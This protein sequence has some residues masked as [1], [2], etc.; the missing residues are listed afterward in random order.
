MDDNLEDY[1]SASLTT[2]QER[3]LAFV[4]EF[5][6]R[7]AGQQH[8]LPRA[9]LKD[10]SVVAECLAIKRLIDEGFLTVPPD[11]TIRTGRDGRWR[12]SKPVASPFR[13]SAY[14][15]DLTISSADLTRHYTFTSADTRWA[16]YSGELEHEATFSNMTD[17]GSCRQKR[18]LE[19]VSSLR[20]AE[21]AGTFI[22]FIDMIHFCMVAPDIPKC[23]SLLV[24]NHAK[25]LRELLRSRQ[26]APK[27]K[28][29]IIPMLELGNAI[30][31]SMPNKTILCVKH[32]TR[33][34]RRIMRSSS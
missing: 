18:A 11:T 34:W 3:V 28:T 31:H 25:D 20:D 21:N 6:L 26:L 19:G 4:Q 12:G 14:P 33:V 24:Q 9:N 29:E 23:V 16:S 17:V 22:Q 2:S 30:S 32:W 15:C 7:R 1:A 5:L 13:S 8:P 27:L 10:P